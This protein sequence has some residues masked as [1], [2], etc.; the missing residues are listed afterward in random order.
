MDYSHPFFLAVR[1]CGQKLGI[2]RPFIRA[3]RKAFRIRY[4]QKFDQVMLEEV[5]AGDIVW[6][7]G[8]NIG[9]FTEKFAAVVGPTGRVVAFEP[10]PGA[11]ETL[12]RAGISMGNITL[13][14]MALADFDGEADF[15]VAPDGTDP[16][17]G[18]F[19]E[20][21]D[22]TVTKVKVI[23]GDQYCSNHPDLTPN[24]IKVDVEGYEYEVL[25]GLRQTLKV[26]SLRSVFIEVHFA[27]LAL[28]G[29]PE[30]PTQITN[31]LRQNGF[32]IRWADAS[33]IIA[34]RMV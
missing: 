5:S 12:K 23:Q 27:A 24:R 13:E 11:F 8:A 10:S 20:R 26:S 31:L 6:D 15:H 30:A 19:S 2:L 21:S 33:H 4:E 16:T 7:V 32:A 34:S 28:R 22:T 29:M 9:F 3:Y 18:L 14:N 17:N 25:M 1:R